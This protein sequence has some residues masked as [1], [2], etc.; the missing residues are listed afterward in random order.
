[1]ADGFLDRGQGLLP[2]PQVAK[3]VAEIDQ[4]SGALAVVGR[5]V[6]QPLE[7]EGGRC[8]EREGGIRARLSDPRKCLAGDR[9]AGKDL[10]QQFTHD[11]VGLD[12]HRERRDG[13][14]VKV[15]GQRTAQHAHRA[16]LGQGRTRQDRQCPG[17]PGLI[18]AGEQRR[19]QLRVS[20]QLAG[21]QLLSEPVRP[22]RAK[23]LPA[24][25]IIRMSDG[26]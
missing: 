22:Q 9:L 21:H 14:V 24:T 5:V 3:A 4:P 26:I 6:S 2:P 19:D 25:W 16:L 1:M 10:A 13:E 7:Y 20:A 23:P 11:R 18:Q 12:R 8:G 17:S 15:G